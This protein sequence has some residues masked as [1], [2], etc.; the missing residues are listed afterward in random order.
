MSVTVIFQKIL[1]RLLKHRN[2]QQYFDFTMRIM[3]DPI[4][5]V[6]QQL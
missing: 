3:L 6:A 4:M 5:I 1:R 2:K